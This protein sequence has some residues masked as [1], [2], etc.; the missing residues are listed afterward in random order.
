MKLNLDCVRDILIEIEKKPFGNK[1][2]LE[3]LTK[4]INHS[5][6]DVL[7]CCL[8]LHEAG[9]I[10]AEVIPPPHPD[11]LPV[12]KFIGELTF[13]GHEFLESIKPLNIWEQIKNTTQELGTSAFAMLKTI[14]I[15]LIKAKFINHL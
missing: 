12:L 1:F 15:E 3:Q 7:Y 13:E 9:L 5:R 4:Q 14:G 11:L 8:K 10:E 6:D 2:D